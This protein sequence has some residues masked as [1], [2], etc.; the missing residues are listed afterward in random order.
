MQE[1]GAKFVE[2]SGSVFR[3]VREAA[4][5]EWQDPQPDTTYYAGLDLAKVEDWTV[6]CIMDAQR[7]VVH[8]DRFHRLDWSLQIERIKAATK[9]Y[10]CNVL[11]DSTGAGEPILESL[12]LNGLWVE[13]YPF[14]AA[15]KAALIANLAMMLEQRLITLP[16]P[17]LWPEGIDEL[18]A[19]EYSISD[20]GNVR[21]SAPSGQ[22][23]DCVIAL[24]LAAW[25][26][27]PQ[28]KFEFRGWF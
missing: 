20:A 24:A 7:R 4:T 22:H 14:T 21:T 17:E 10:G 12:R 25:W 27:R 26:L 11:V 6:L 13:P 5:G 3:Y 16:R 28:P 15:S 9:R 19:F 1:Y 2:G 8:V 23:D 18:E